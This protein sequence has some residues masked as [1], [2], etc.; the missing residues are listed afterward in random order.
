MTDDDELAHTRC[1]RVAYLRASTGVAEGAV[2]RKLGRR[3]SDCSLFWGC[4]GWQFVGI[5]G[6]VLLVICGGELELS[7]ELATAIFHALALAAP[8][9]PG[10]C[11]GVV[12]FGGLA[13]RVDAFGDVAIYWDGYERTFAVVGR[14][15][16]HETL[17]LA[18]T[19]LGTPGQYCTHVARERGWDVGEHIGGSPV[20]ARARVTPRS[21]TDRRIRTELGRWLRA[22]RVCLDG[23]CLAGDRPGSG[24]NGASG[25]TGPSL[26]YDDSR[27]SSGPS[28]THELQFTSIISIYG[29]RPS[30]HS[31][32][33][34]TS[35]T[36]NTPALAAA[37][38]LADDLRV[39]VW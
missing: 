36:P 39:V 16:D 6:W 30:S 25:L 22:P 29:R 34:S 14:D 19:P 3:D 13:G 15:G 28:A 2:S 27:V 35:A 23:L 37:S 12:F 7:D 26:L 10:R 32:H 20:D 18:D 4:C 38:L 33:T 31:T 1:N 24:R 11:L 5:L 9:L 17:A 21:E 8:S